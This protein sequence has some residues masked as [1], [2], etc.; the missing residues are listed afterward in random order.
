MARFSFSGPACNRGR[1]A[2]VFMAV[3][4][5]LACAASALAGGGNVQP[6]SAKP[7]GYSLSDM[8][9]ETAAFNVG[10]RTGT[11]PDV[12]FHVLVDDATV[13][14]GTMLYL[15]VFFAD[16]APPATNPPFPEDVTDQEADADYLL[17]TVA[18]V[19]AF[20]VQVD[21]KTTI[22]S[23]NYVSGVTTAPLP[24]G[25]TG[26][27]VSAAFLTPLT[28]G[29]HTVGIG[30]VIHGAPVVFVSYNVTVEK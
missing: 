16:N 13:K 4:G 5:V 3:V 30:A 24:D 7:K 20:V 9:V 14:P 11:A 6:P 1:T 26:Y 27:I 25:A 29:K 10:P 23:D 21:G 19:P 28:P 18:G 15:P 17:D 8:A 2:T 12:P 22:L